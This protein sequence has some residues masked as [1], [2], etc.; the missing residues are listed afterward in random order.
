MRS[1]FSENGSP[2]PR[3]GSNRAYGAAY[4]TV[5]SAECGGLN[6]DASASSALLPRRVSTAPPLQEPSSPRDKRPGPGGSSSK[7]LE[8]SSSKA[9]MAA[10]DLDAG[11]RA[12]PERSQLTKVRCVPLF[13]CCIRPRPLSACD[14]G[15]LL[16]CAAHRSARG[17]FTS[18]RFAPS[19]RRFARQASSAGPEGI[20]K[21]CSSGRS[22][23]SPVH[24]SSRGS[25]GDF[26]FR[27]ESVANLNCRA[28]HIIGRWS[29][30][31][32]RNRA[33]DALRRVAVGFLKRKAMMARKQDSG[34][35]TLQPSVL[36]ERYRKKER[37]RQKAIEE[38]VNKHLSLRRGLKHLEAARRDL[39]ASARQE[40]EAAGKGGEL[41]RGGGWAKH[42]ERIFAVV[43]STADVRYNR[44]K[45]YSRYSRYTWS[46]S[47]QPSTRR[48]RCVTGR[49]G[50]GTVSVRGWSSRA[51][52]MRT[53]PALIQPHARTCAR[54]RRACCP[55]RN[56]SPR[57]SSSR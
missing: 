53:P 27:A 24:R 5:S 6:V 17:R 25:S 28:L 7:L 35:A 39:L 12:G 23:N 33:A 19:F 51:T 11:W 18:H 38:L 32:E 4:S 48:R 49:D 10:L 30:P 29:T 9:T 42:V 31:L 40:D 47:S 44:Y 14:R 8:Q 36:L 20:P 13:S 16:P 2:S 1:R 56:A 26:L 21:E 57:S 3:G 41:T 52:R 46:G 22:S 15:A 43:D 37:Q 34:S 55:R 50:G 45:R 54:L